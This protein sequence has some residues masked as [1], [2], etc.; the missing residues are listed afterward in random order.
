MRDDMT[1]ARKATTPKVYESLQYESVDVFLLL[2]VCQQCGKDACVSPESFMSSLLGCRPCDLE[3]LV[4][5]FVPIFHDVRPR[6]FLYSGRI[7]GRMNP[8]VAGL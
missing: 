1:S 5:T 3:M 8:E 7:N 2:C 4:S 6:L